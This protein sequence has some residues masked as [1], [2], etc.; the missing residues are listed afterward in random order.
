MKR[1]IKFYKDDKNYIFKESD[2][3][4]IEISIG[5]KKLDGL[6]LYDAFFKEYNIKDSFEIIDETDDGQK[7]EDKMCEAIYDKMCELFE[8]IEKTLERELAPKDNVGEK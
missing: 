2:N 7:K 8:K 5:E 6:K 4:K 3:N 1:T